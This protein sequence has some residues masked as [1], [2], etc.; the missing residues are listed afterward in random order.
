MYNVTQ[1]SCL[2]GK[3]V[4]TKQCGCPRSSSSC[5]VGMRDMRAVHTLYPALQACGVTERVARG[6]T[7]IE[8]L[9]VVLIIG[10]LAAVALPQYN[11][12]V[13]KARA[14]EAVTI[15][16]ALQKG[17]DMY[18]L[19]HGLSEKHITFLGESYEEQGGDEIPLSTA[20]LN[21]DI[22]GLQKCA[23][24]AEH[25][26]YCYND[27]FIYYAYCYIDNRCRLVAARGSN[28]EWQNYGANDADVLPGK[29]SL[30]K[31]RNPATNQWSKMCE[32]C[33]FNLVW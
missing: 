28:T 1:I 8:L 12:A 10:I 11:K 30:V 21:I 4:E 26:G 25:Q 20:S 15:L 18:I 17:V 27:H 16:T 33:S 9:V 29:Y 32:D 31:E 5:S 13:E 22:P 7:L 14:T 3:E 23:Q 19:E 6:F 24:D 2:A